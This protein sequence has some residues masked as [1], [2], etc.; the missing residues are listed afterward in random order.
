MPA[1]EINGPFNPLAFVKFGITGWLTLFC[2]VRMGRDIAEGGGT[3]RGILGGIAGRFP[4]PKGICIGNGMLGGGIIP[5]KHEHV[6]LVF[7][8]F[9]GNGFKHQLNCHFLTQPHPLRSMKAT[10]A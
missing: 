8:H 1:A 10:L 4:E 3:I 9:E 2:G 7:H 6:C 5:T